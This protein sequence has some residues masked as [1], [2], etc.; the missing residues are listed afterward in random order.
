MI[1]AINDSKLKA[2]VYYNESIDALAIVSKSTW[3]LVGAKIY[4]LSGWKR[5]GDL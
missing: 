1:W 5:I 3:Y 4:P 2:G